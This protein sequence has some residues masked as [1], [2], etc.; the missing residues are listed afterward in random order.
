MKLSIL[1]QKDEQQGDS[2]KAQK[3]LIFTKSVQLGNFVH[4]P[5]MDKAM[6]QQ[7]SLQNFRSSPLLSLPIEILKIIVVLLT[8]PLDLFSF[9]CTCTGL[10]YIVLSNDW[11]SL[12]R[13]LFS[14]W[15][16]SCGQVHERDWRNIVLKDA[17][18]SARLGASF[19]S[20]Q[21]V[22]SLRSLSLDNKPS[23]LPSSP[24][25][26]PHRN[27]E[28]DVTT[29]RPRLRVCLEESQI[30]D[31]D[32]ETRGVKDSPWIRMASPIYHIDSD[33]KTI[34]AASMIT[35]PKTVDKND[36]SRPHDHEVL[37]YNPPDITNPIARCGSDVWEMDNK[38]QPWYQPFMR[39]MLQVAQIVEIKH[40][41]GDVNNDGMRIIIVVAF[42]QRAR[43]LEGN[44]ADAHI[45]GV[46]LMLKII[47]FRIPIQRTTEL[48]PMLMNHFRTPS[49]TLSAD[50][51]TCFR[52]TREH[53]LR[54][55][56]IEPRQHQI[57]MNGRFVKIYSAENP[58]MSSSTKQVDCIVIFGTQH[59]DHAAAMV[60]R[61]VL[62]YND[63]GKRTYS[64]KA[65]SRGVSCMTLFPDHS[66][67]EYL[68]VLFNQHGRGMIWDWVHEKQILQLHMSPDAVSHDPT[69]RAKGTEVPPQDR[70]VY[71]WGVQVSSALELPFP[72]NLNN[73]SQDNGNNNN[74]INNINNIS[75]ITNTNTVTDTNYN[76][77]NN[78][79]VFRIVTMADG[80]EDEWESCWWNITSD[81][82]PPKMK[83]LPSPHIQDRNNF[84]RGLTAPDAAKEPIMSKDRR[85][86]RKTLGI[87]LPDQEELHPD[88][89]DQSIQFIAYVVWNHYR[90]A[91]STRMGIC[92][93]DIEE[94]KSDIGR[95]WITFLP[96]RQDLI[97]IAIFG[98]NLIVTLKTGHQVW[99]FYGPANKPFISKEGLGLRIDSDPIH[100]MTPLVY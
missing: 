44:A 56:S 19:E 62:F 5:P 17:A 29:Q 67:Y 61:K 16:D 34:I 28:D 85:Y 43:P 82:L 60:I 42:G 7:L 4:R 9:S 58:E 40:F 73:Q 12:A 14:K 66:G 50:T 55:E 74:N 95:Q 71:Y 93:M 49:N 84:P 30:F 8:D 20:K 11:Y 3:I 53:V 92:M 96:E 64:N 18:L 37:I 78:N 13:Y 59:S 80:M 63:L 70:R 69:N 97:D 23:F 10:Y 98:H 89:K 81:D 38:G 26:S 83:S 99:S 31:S 39:D 47:E 45:L 36:G 27:I 33:H 24:L 54:F 88:M 77:N 2:P 46:W 32:P 41:P 57:T 15:I 35:R 72:G 48:T 22:A 75:T 76:N 90:I 94:P 21:P 68:L 52:V 100:R 87:C 25:I 1:E 51:P 6:A 79:N 65:V 91:L 86:E